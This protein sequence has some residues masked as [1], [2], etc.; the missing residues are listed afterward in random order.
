[1]Q[2]EKKKVVLKLG[3]VVV[4]LREHLLPPV[5]Y[6]EFLLGLWDQCES[7]VVSAWKAG[8]SR[9]YRRGFL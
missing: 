6:R 1:M 3:E 7:I 4:P 9:E 5:P 2:N 8:A